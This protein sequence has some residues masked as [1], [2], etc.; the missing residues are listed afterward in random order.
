MHMIMQYNLIWKKQNDVEIRGELIIGKT[1]ENISKH[2]LTVFHHQY[3]CGVIQKIEIQLLDVKILIE[4]GNTMF[5]C[6]FISL[7]SYSPQ[8]KNV[9]SFSEQ[10][11]L[12]LQFGNASVFM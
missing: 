5:L 4:S 8:N 11:F 9:A 6:F 10:V 3:G 7:L 12:K 1:T 2:Q